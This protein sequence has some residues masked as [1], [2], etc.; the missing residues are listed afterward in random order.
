MFKV[1]AAL[2]AGIFYQ[3]LQTKTLLILSFIGYMIGLSFYIWNKD[4]IIL[5]LAKILSGFCQ[6]FIVIFNPV[7][8]DKNAYSKKTLWLTF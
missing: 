8:I 5:S 3:K 7:W 2:M 6:I 4:L 1:S